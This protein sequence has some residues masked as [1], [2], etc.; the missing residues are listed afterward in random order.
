MKKAIRNRRI[1]FDCLLLFHRNTSLSV[2]PSLVLFL[3]TV[4]YIKVNKMKY[5]ISFYSLIVINNL[6]WW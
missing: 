4:A 3:L 6:Q 5:Y 1:I 2:I